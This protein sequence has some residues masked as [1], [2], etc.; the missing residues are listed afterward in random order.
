MNH[1]VSIGERLREERV[2]LGMSQT[3]FG[4]AG[5]VTKKTQMLYE[6][7]ERAPDA[8]YL[9]ALSVAGIDVGYVVTGERGPGSHVLDGAEQVLLDSYRRCKPE[10][11]QNL[12]QTAALLSAGMP[13]ATAPGS[14]MVMSNLGDGNVQVGSGAQVSVKRTK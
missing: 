8:V 4:E 5:G 7:G 10:A 1:L 11:R 13:A 9:H 12:I 2:R 3:V 14:S 6:G